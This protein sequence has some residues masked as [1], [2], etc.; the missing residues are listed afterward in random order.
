MHTEE[1]G[2]ESIL[3]GYPER[4]NR[5][6]DRDGRQW[7]GRCIFHSVRTGEDRQRGDCVQPQ[8]LYTDESKNRGTRGRYLF[9]Q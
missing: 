3:Y 5:Q 6:S 8:E 7:E 9:Y 2:T 1:D 4:R